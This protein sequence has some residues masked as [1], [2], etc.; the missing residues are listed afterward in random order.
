MHGG[1]TTGSEASGLLEL[2]RCCERQGQAR[3]VLR[4]TL[5][6]TEHALAK[7]RLRLGEL[8]TASRREVAGGGGLDA[9]L[10]ADEVRQRVR[11]LEREGAH[12]RRL[13]SEPDSTPE[14]GHLALWLQDEAEPH[15]ARV[16]RTVIAGAGPGV[17]RE[18]LAQLRELRGDPE[19]AALIRAAAD[20]PFLLAQCLGSHLAARGRM[21]EHPF[22]VYRLTQAD[23]WREGIG[24]E[25]PGAQRC[26]SL[27][28]A[29]NR[30]PG[31]PDA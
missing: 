31:T 29:M 12:L 6:R 30:R 25:P 18:V 19:G 20:Q 28:E 23:L 9:G 21:I 11:Y 26:Q 1:P 15:A 2:A 4:E 16:A 13:I 14:Q 3:R 24:R 8:E 5:E 10:A 22:Q 7:G 17:T 27:G